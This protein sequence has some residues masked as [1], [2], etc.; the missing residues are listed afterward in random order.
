MWKMIEWNF[1]TNQNCMYNY[2]NSELNLINIFA[3]VCVFV[4]PFQCFKMWQVQNMHKRM[5]L[6]IHSRTVR[7]SNHEPWLLHFNIHPQKPSN[8][9]KWSKNYPHVFI[10]TWSTIEYD[11]FCV[12]RLWLQHK[13]QKSSNINDQP[14]WMLAVVLLFFSI[15]CSFPIC[16]VRQNPG[17]MNVIQRRN[18]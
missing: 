3:Q 10:Y 7:Q 18:W 15:L 2:Y 17:T 12:H 1:K 14:I 13:F 8:R 16:H 9:V 6:N 4:A 5:N 11:V